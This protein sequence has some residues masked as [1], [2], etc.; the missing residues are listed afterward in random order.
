MTYE[1]KEFED[2]AWVLKVEVVPPKELGTGR[3]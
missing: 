2:I 1:V 3:S